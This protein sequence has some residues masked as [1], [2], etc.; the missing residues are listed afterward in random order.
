MIKVAIV[1]YGNLG[2]G[3]EKALALQSDM[4]CVGIFTRREPHTIKAQNPVYSIEG[5]SKHQIDVAILCG[6][7]ATDLVHQ[8][9]SLLKECNIV[10]SF[11]THAKIPE[12]FEKMNQ[13]AKENG[14]LGMIS[15]GWDPGLFSMIRL[16]AESALPQGESTTFWGYGVS[17]GHSDAIRRIE[18]VRHAVQYTIPKEEA[19]EMT[20]LGKGSELTTRDKHLRRCF[21]VLEETALEEKVK[22]AIVSMP[23]YFSDYDTEVNFI[24]EEVFFNEHMTMPHGG[25]VIYRGKTS[26]ENIQTIQFKLALDSNPEFTASVNVACA[27]AVYRAFNE[28]RVGAVTMFDLPLAYLSPKTDEA[29]RKNLL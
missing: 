1:G 25:T 20:M 16:L 29:L 6:G 28:G 2:K 19:V 21:V 23:H 13:V 9:P 18:G 15:T 5:I 11:D 3:V 17:Q 27:R 24:S 14:R 8:G 7:S 26:E 22:E 12:Y 4:E 10:D